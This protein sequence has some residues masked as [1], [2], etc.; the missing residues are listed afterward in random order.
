MFSPFMRP[1]KPNENIWYSLNLGA[2]FVDGPASSDDF[3]HQIRQLNLGADF[4]KG[5][6]SPGNTLSHLSVLD[7]KQPVTVWVTMENADQRG[8]NA[9]DRKSNTISVDLNQWPK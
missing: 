6:T 8:A 7:P 1:I 2:D 5:P 3:E 9:L 4:V